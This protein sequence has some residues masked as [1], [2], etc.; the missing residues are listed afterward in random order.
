MQT[1]RPAVAYTLDGQI[2]LL[3]HSR[4]NQILRTVSFDEG[5]NWLPWR[6][7]K[8]HKTRLPV[9]FASTADGRAKFLVYQVLNLLDDTPF[10]GA[11]KDD[12]EYVFKIDEH[13]GF[14]WD[15]NA[16]AMGGDGKFVTGPSVICSPS[17]DRVYIFGLGRDRKL[18]WALY[19][20]HNKNWLWRWAKLGDNLLRS[21][22]S[23]VMSADGQTMMIFT[24]GND[25]ECQFHRSNDGG[26]NWNIYGG[27][28]HQGRFNSGL[29]ACMSADGS[30]VLVA[31]RGRDN[32]IWTISSDNQGNSWIND[33]APIG[34]GV[35]TGGPGICGNWD[36][37]KVFVFGVGN[38]HKIWKAHRLGK[39]QPF[40]G[41]W[42]ADKENK[43]TAI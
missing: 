27:Q 31:G 3:I 32:R 9:G 35:C 2:D 23:V 7:M 15:D 25:Y 30:E 1:H 36:L 13:F 11:F 5:E 43:L 24:V 6:K 41:W 22:P 42:P 20:N 33:W 8:N 21:E 39:H 19:D 14:S 38:D 10:E 29:S 18:Y 37:S 12:D 40:A 4:S 28:I 34:E 26:A 17:G 16:H